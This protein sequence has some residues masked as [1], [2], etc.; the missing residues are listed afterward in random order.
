[1]STPGT[2]VSLHQRILARFTEL[3]ESNPEVSQS[4]KKAFRALLAH[5]GPLTRDKIQQAIVSA[6]GAQSAGNQAS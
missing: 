1:M 3:I 2:S 4:S 5:G 6:A